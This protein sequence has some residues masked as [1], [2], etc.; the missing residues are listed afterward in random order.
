MRSLLMLALIAGITGHAA[1]AGAQSRAAERA[2]GRAVS[3]E[4][5]VQQIEAATPNGDAAYLLMHARVLTTGAAGSGSTTAGQ[6][7][8]GRGRPDG[9]NR[10]RGGENPLPA[11]N[12]EALQNALPPNT[13]PGNQSTNVA[14]Q[15]VLDG[16]VDLAPYVGKQVL[17]GGTLL[18]ISTNPPNPAAAR[19]AQST[20]NPVLEVE[21]VSVRAQQCAQR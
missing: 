3:I 2:Q 9:A 1:P 7:A 12:P 4:G 10:T 8:G 19:S 16:R 6:R 5:C 13:P 14:R 11:T 18:P 21:K 20:G 15:Y 17:V